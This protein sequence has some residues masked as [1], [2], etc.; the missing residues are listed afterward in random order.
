MN[1]LVTKR[2]YLSPYT[3]SDLD[4]LL[5]LRSTEAVWTYSTSK[6]D[7]SQEGA[8]G[9][10]ETILDKYAKGEYAQFALFKKDGTY[11]GEAGVY[12]G[13]VE[14]RKI[15]IGYNLLPPFWGNGFATEITKAIINWYLENS[16]IQRIEATVLEDNLASRRVL[17]KSNM[18]LEGVLRKF[19]VIDGSSRNLCF[20]SI[21]R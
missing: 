3:R 14:Y 6:A 19:T 1:R 18:Q 9:Q 21:V 8:H 15:N 16:D 10:L 13:N 7:S 12:H 11:I 17:E 4:N 20:Y 5:L 2:L